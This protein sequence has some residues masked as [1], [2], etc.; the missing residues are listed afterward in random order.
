MR[1][2]GALD[3]R[4]GASDTARRRRRTAAATGRMMS[5]TGQEKYDA[6]EKDELYDLLSS[7]RRRYVLH[8]CKQTEEPVTLSELAEQVTAWEHDKTVP[9]ITSSERKRVYTSLQQT[10]LDRLENAGLVEYDGDEVSLTSDAK[11]LDVYLDIV[12]PQSISWGV[13]YLGLSLLAGVV[14]GG[15]WVGFVPTE[16]VPELGWAG[17]VLVAFLVSSVA[18]VVQI[19]RNRLDQ[20]ERPP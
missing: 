15:V 19:R 2:P 3:Y 17:L 20:F 5:L 18:H 13:Y 12:P 10:H 14:L 1:G 7:H 6:P 8:Y 11:G 16:T 9:E 4:T